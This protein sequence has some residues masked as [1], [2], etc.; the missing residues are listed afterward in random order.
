[1]VDLLWQIPGEAGLPKLDDG[2]RLIVTLVY[3]WLIRFFIFGWTIER[4]PAAR[5]FQILR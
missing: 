4:Q 1:M 2:D 3:E 5:R